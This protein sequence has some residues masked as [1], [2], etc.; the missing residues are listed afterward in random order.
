MIARRERPT[1][2]FSPCGSTVQE[3]EPRSSFL[4]LVLLAARAMSSVTYLS[5]QNL[6]LH[7]ANPRQ[8]QR[9]RR[10]ETWLADA[11][12]SKYTPAFAGMDEQSFLELMMQVWHG[13]LLL[14]SC[15]VVCPSG[16]P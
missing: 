1:L 2:G 7:C 15:L 5:P 6:A 3:F 11:G 8:S 13:H 12:L 9:M 14:H 16:T 4:L 10:V